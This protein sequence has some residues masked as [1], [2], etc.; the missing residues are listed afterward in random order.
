MSSFI[1][2]FQ[3]GFS[4]QLFEIFLVGVKFTKQF[5]D[6]FRISASGSLSPLDSLLTLTRRL[7]VGNCRLLLVLLLQLPDKSA[8]ANIITSD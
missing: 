6:S 1:S 7:A 2:T 5:F 4:Q 8:L 3:T